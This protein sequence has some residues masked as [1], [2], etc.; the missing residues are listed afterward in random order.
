MPEALYNLFQPPSPLNSS[1]KNGMEELYGLDNIQMM[2]WSVLAAVPYN[3][4]HILQENCKKTFRI[5]LPT[6]NSSCWND[7]HS[8][9]LWADGTIRCVP[10]GTSTMTSCLLRSVC[11]TGS[12]HRSRHL[13]ELSGHGAV[14]LFR[15]WASRSMVPVNINS[16][17]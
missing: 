15:L 5:P 10:M 7:G 14:L 11:S 4:S 6:S 16:E 8:N 3:L 13:Y 2:S 12:W 17:K 9:P 1:E